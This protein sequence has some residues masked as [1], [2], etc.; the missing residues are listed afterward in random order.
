MRLLSVEKRGA[1]EKLLEDAKKSG[2]VRVRVDGIIYDLSEEIKLEKNKKHTIEI[3]VDR[4]VVKEG[5]QKRLTRIHRNCHRTRQGD[6]W[7]WM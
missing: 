3:I 7:W 5:I 6:Y 4:L 2:Y 1:C